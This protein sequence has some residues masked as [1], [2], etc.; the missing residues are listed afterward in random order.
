MDRSARIAAPSRSAT[1]IVSIPRQLERWMAREVDGFEGPLTVEQFKGGQSNPTYKLITP[2]RSY[3]LRRKP[4]GKLLPGAHAVDR[5]YRVI[6]RARRAGLPGRPRLWPVHGR[7]GG[8]HALL[9]D[10]DGRGPDL[11]GDRLSAGRRTSER[12]A[13]FDAMNATIARLH[14][15]RSG[16][17]RARRLWQAGQLFRAP[18]RP[19]VEAISRRRRGRPG[20]RRWT[21][22]SNGCPRNIPG[23]ARSRSADHP[24]RFSLRQYGLPP[25]RAEGAGGARLGAVDARPSAR[26]L[27]LSS[28]DV[29][30]AGGRLDRAGR[31]RSR[32][33]ATSR[34]KRIMSPLI[35]AEPAA[36][37]S[38]TSISTWRSTCSGSPRSFTGSRAGS[39]RGTASSAHA[40]DDGGEPRGHRRSRLGAG[41][42][43]RSSA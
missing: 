13:Y 5:E 37:G 14:E 19:L 4:P 27:H 18:D 40:G 6:S 29:P 22:W 43:G 25:D 2:G 3:V 15:N 42:E 34:P 39:A 9:R 31:P 16:S 11:L 20:R 24:R 32:G 30:D 38:P 1:P 26:R 33:A 23:T 41:G 17:G 12:P 10:G 7:G 36:T 28:D 8:R 21:G 35:A